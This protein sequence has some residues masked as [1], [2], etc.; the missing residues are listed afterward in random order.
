M[1]DSRWL[2]FVLFVSLSFAFVAKENQP[3][4]NNLCGESG[5]EGVVGHDNDVFVYVVVM[6][7][8]HTARVNECLWLLCVRITSRTEVADLSLASHGMQRNW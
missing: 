2:H 1:S 7:D 5:E 3:N 8:V 6:G 4:R